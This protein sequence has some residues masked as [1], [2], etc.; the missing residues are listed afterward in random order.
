MHRIK[1]V[2]LLNW[3]LSWHLGEKAN[4]QGREAKDLNPCFYCGSPNLAV[5]HWE[6]RIVI[7]STL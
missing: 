5:W 3:H 2:F 6:N 7:I 4:Q 1:T